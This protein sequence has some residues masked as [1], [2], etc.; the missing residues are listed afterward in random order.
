M[1]SARILWCVGLGSS[2]LAACAKSPDPPTAPRSR[3]ITGHVRL[4]GYFTHENGLFAGTR[5]LGDADGVTVELVYG[6]QVVDRTTTMDGIY[7]FSDVAPG[8]YIARTKVVG[9]IGDH[10]GTLT[11]A[12]SSVSATDTLRLN[13]R[14]DLYPV[15]NPFA[16]TLQVFFDVL[17]PQTVD[18]RI[19]DISGNTVRRL[20]AQDLG[21]GFNG[22]IW[23][24]R[25]QRGVPANG[26]LYWV[27]YVAAGDVRA[28]LLF[29]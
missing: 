17:E 9:D 11:V 3:S 12:T 14:G 16:D 21:P 2:L 24:G 1:K 15:P 29:K 13:S 6:S 23:D 20:L 27:T 5:V 19:L 7:I 22:V 26:S 8:G 25:D 18:I 28:Q 4:T 10:T